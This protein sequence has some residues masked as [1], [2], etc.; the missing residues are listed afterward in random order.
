M[1]VAALR[2]YQH[3]PDQLFAVDLPLVVKR[4][5]DEIDYTAGMATNPATHESVRALFNEQ[6]RS[7]ERGRAFIMGVI[8]Q[9][10]G[11]KRGPS[12]G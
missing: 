8:D 7:L 2:P 10:Q 1:N 11:V 5:T 3:S 6:L 9:H 4:L 12:Q